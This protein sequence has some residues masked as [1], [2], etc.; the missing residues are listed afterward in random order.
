MR[1]L[2]LFLSTVLAVILLTA[3]PTAAQEPLEMHIISGSNEYES[4]ASLT[5]YADY[6]EERYHVDITA[7]WVQDRATNLPGIE[8]IPEA[9][10]LLIFTRRMELPDEQMQVI[11]AHWQDGK[12]IVGVRTASHAFREEANQV[13]DH[14]VMGGNYTGHFGDEDVD[15]RSLVDHPVLDGVEDFTSRRMYKA[16]RLA[17]D[18]QILQTGT[19]PSGQTHAVTWVHTYNGGRMFYTSLGVPEDFERESFVRM[20]TNAIF[21]TSRRSRSALRR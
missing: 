8:H 1:A 15:V 2:N 19:I 9:D 6:L 3:G 4:E 17:E 16:G 5:A 12:P 10:L 13:F 18:A 7:S 14:E 21:W 11:E 20:L